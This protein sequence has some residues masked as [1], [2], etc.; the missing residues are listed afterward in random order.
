MKYVVMVD[1]KPKD[2]N[3]C[4]FYHETF[5]ETEVKNTLKLEKICFLKS[6]EDSP[7]PL[8][9]IHTVFVTDEESVSENVG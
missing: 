8:T 4:M 3:E 1:E 7:C 9:E 6:D 2:C 5:L